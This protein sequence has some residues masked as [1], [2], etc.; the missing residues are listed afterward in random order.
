MSTSPNT[1]SAG[2]PANASPAELLY[3]DMAQ[4]L[5]NTR[6]LLERIPDGKD[7]WKPHG[8]SMAL[9]NLATHVAELPRFATMILTTDEFDFGAGT[10]PKVTITSNADRL[11]L[12]DEVAAGMV[13]GI[14]SATWP[15]LDRNW[16]MRMG[17][18]VFMNDRKANLLRGTISH[19]AHHRAQLGVYLRQL[20]I[21][22]PGM[23]GPSAD[24]M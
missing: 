24:E 11:A 9:G 5:A 1:T 21:T 16:K 3:P 2:F 17:E 15:A 23:Y 20:D 19:I 18:Q 10:W 22:I 6:R 13:S 7:D 12:F 4:E 8:K 14:N